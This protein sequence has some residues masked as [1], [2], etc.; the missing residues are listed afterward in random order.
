MLM[1]LP[2]TLLER[3]DTMY[4]LAKDVFLFFRDNLALIASNKLVFLFFALIIGFA[5]YIVCKTIHACKSKT[6]TCENERL[7]IENKELSEEVDELKSQL[8]QCDV[9]KFVTSRGKNTNDKFA[10]KLVEDFSSDK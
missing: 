9:T 8:S 6:L 2:N 4:S 5:T 7:K 1:V 3:R 10:E